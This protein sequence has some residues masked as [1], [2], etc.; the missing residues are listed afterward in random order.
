MKNTIAGRRKKKIRKPKDGESI[1]PTAPRR[2]RR[3]KPPD[4]EERAIGITSHPERRPA[5]RPC[6][7]RPPWQRHANAGPRGRIDSQAALT[8]SHIDSQSSYVA[9][10]SDWRGG[11]E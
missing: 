2:S 1:Q 3:R 7:P 4:V 6:S 11:S 5:A 10:V 9:K 8:S